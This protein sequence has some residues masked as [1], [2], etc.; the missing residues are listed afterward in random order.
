VLYKDTGR[1]V[2]TD[3]HLSEV[4]KLVDAAIADENPTNLPVEGFP[5]IS[6]PQGNKEPLLAIDP[7]LSG[8]VSG[9]PN[10]SSPEKDGGPLP[11]IDSTPL[12]VTDGLP[13]LQ[14]EEDGWPPLVTMGI[15]PML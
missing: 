14:P 13:M 15:D 2:R 6:S 9:F 7:F 5:N 1:H 11:T 3:G 12:Y 10:E 4:Y 8:L